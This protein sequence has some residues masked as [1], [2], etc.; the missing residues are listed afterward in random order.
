MPAASPSGTSLQAEVR[1]K[2]A[3]SGPASASN[4]PTL[5]AFALLARSRALRWAKAYGNLQ[6]VFSLLFGSLRI[7]VATTLGRPVVPRRFQR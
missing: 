5:D 2:M 1:A 4:A 6:A 3:H 7:S